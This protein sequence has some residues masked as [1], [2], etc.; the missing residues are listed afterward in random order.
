MFSIFK[1][2]KQ[3]SIDY[4]YEIDKVIE[5]FE[6]GDY[7]ETSY[8]VKSKSQENDKLSKEIRLVL[9]TMEWIKGYEHVNQIYMIYHGKDDVQ[10]KALFHK[11]IKLSENITGK[12]GVYRKANHDIENYVS[13]EEDTIL[14]MIRVGN[15]V[16]KVCASIEQQEEIK[17]VLTQLNEYVY[18]QQK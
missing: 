14:Y 2:R 8:K 16:I 13:R 10:A 18:K 1:T 3:Q 7:I 17:R 4:M 11:Y 15:D 9:E 12:D 6:K 5:Y